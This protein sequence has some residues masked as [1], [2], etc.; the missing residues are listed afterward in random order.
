[1]SLTAPNGEPRPD[2]PHRRTLVL[3]AAGTAI[4]AGLTWAGSG[5]ADG[6][7]GGGFGPLGRGPGMMGTMLLDQFDADGDGKVS[8]AEV[9]A[10]RKARLESADRNRDG[11]L[12]QVE[13]ETLWLEVTRPMRIRAF[14]MLDADGDGIVTAVELERPVNRMFARMD[15]DGDGFLA[16]MTGAD[17]ERMRERMREERRERGPRHH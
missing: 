4:V 5:L 9:D 1:M 12:D 14:Q 6:W 15:R 10:F 13:F 11:R 8:R 16:P 7:P 3:L 17:R 2:R